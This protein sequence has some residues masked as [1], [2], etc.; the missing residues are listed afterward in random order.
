MAPEASIQ[1]YPLYNTTFSLHRVSPL[2]I[3]THLPLNNTNLRD[4]ARQ[5]RD[6]LTGEVLRGVRVGLAPED[7]TLSRVG[8]LQTVTW[9]VLPE[10]EAWA[11]DETEPGNDDT[12][13]VLTSSRGMLVTVTYEKMTYK[14]ILLRDDRTSDPDTTLGSIREGMEE[15]QH[16]PLLLSKMPG[17]LRETFTDYLATTFDTRISVLHLS[18]KYLTDTFE[19]YIS[20]LS[21]D[22]DGE[23]MDMIDRSRTLRTIIKETLFFIGFDLPSASLKTIDISI[24]REDLP[25]MVARG[26]KLGRQADGASPF[27]DALAAYVKGHMALDMRHEGVKIVRVAC[28]AFVLGAEGKIK[29]TQPTSSQDEISPQRRATRRLI[30]DLVAAAVGGALAGKEG[31]T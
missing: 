12:T 1:Q 13:T 8:A 23:L 20:D 10:E 26:K 24:A 7:D 29:L 2:Y 6:I 21:N 19:H 25:R 11:A 30:N 31:A 27:F 3:G 18:S 14:A 22:E 4:H 28:G 16:F 17:P 5:F 15:F 9:K